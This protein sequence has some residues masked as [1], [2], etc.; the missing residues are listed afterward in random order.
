MDRGRRAGAGDFD[1][2]PGNDLVVLRLSASNDGVVQA[3]LSDIHYLRAGRV[4][5]AVST[6]PYRSGFFNQRT[7]SQLI[8]IYS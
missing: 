2:T 8:A 5:P 1:R 6:Y 3:G 4:F 7:A